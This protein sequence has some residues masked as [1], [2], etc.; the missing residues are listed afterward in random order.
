MFNSVHRKQA[1]CEWADW[2]SRCSSRNPGLA[3]QLGP[4]GAHR[5]PHKDSPHAPAWL[6]RALT[7][8]S[9]VIKGSSGC[10]GQGYGCDPPHTTPFSPHKLEGRME[11]VEGGAYGVGGHQVLSLPLFFISS[12]CLCGSAGVPFWPVLRSFFL[13]LFLFMDTH[14]QTCIHTHSHTQNTHSGQTPSSN[15]SQAGFYRLDC[16]KTHSPPHTHPH[17]T[18]R[19]CSVA[20]QVPG[21]VIALLMQFLSLLMCKSVC[22]WMP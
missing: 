7:H 10:W 6:Q 13:F 4:T 2:S 22:V 20:L 15:P 8:I 3:G 19:L 1:R 11:R 5:E 17:N 18:D 9:L 16:R 21:M 14:T 12:L